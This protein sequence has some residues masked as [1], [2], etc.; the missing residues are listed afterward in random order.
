MFDKVLFVGAYDHV[1]DNGFG[2]EERLDNI[3]KC[4]SA[5]K[6]IYAYQHGD[7]YHRRR[8]YFC[9]WTFHDCSPYFQSIC[10]S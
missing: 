2:V 7:N 5:S 6:W 4:Y 9:H 10:R 8:G 3:G 1:E